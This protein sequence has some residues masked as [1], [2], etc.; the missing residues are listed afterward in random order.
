MKYISNTV[1]PNSLRPNIEYKETGK[2][3]VAQLS[4]PWSNNSPNGED[5]LVLL[6]CLPSVPSFYNKK[7]SFKSELKTD[8][9]KKSHKPKWCDKNWNI[10]PNSHKIGGIQE[11]K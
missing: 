7:K 3:K 4:R 10:A 9:K 5:V 1:A 2:N 6:A 8:E 11:H